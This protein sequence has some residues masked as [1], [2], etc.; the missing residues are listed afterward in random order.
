MFVNALLNK[1][2]F[3]IIWFIRNY[4]TLHL[5]FEESPFTFDIVICVPEPFLL[6]GNYSSF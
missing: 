1:F 6:N 3:V 2:G 5:A 4:L